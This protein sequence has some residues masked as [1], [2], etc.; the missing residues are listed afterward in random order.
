MES[1]TR[2]TR[3]FSSRNGYTTSAS[4]SCRTLPVHNIGRH[5]RHTDRSD[6]I[7]LRGDVV[8][9]LD[10]VIVKDEGNL[11]LDDKRHKESKA[12]SEIVFP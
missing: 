8:L 12:H 2:E 5:V 6:P 7:I 9:Y 1:R 11:D 10:I 4:G 3:H